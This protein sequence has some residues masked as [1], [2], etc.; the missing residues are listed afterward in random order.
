MKILIINTTKKKY[1]GKVY[2]RMVGEAL[3]NNFKVELINAGIKNGK[4]KYLK[5][6]TILWNLFKVSRK[7]EFDFA[8][9][10][11]DASLFLN[12][13]PTKNIAIVHHIDSSCAP[14]FLKVAYSFF[15]KIVLRNLK[16]FDAIVTVSKYWRDY[17]IERNYKNVYLIYNA[18][19]L[20]EFNF[21]FE[22]IEEFK[23][24]YNL[25]KKPIVYLGN[26]Q[27]AKGV[28]EEYKALKDLDVYLITSGEPMVEI[29]ATNLN[30]SRRNYLKLLKASSIVI[31]MSKFKEGWCRSA[32]ESMLLKTPVIGSGLGGMRELLE[33]GKQIICQDF[34]LLRENVRYLLSHSEARKKMGDNGYSF[35]KDFTLE[36]FE[37]DWLKL[38][39]RLI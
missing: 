39:K 27:K 6:P 16:K 15:E 19:N 35:A 10:D 23:K 18:F 3:S 32:H 7:K 14:L 21:S 24:R 17:F 5:V 13:E 1:G 22:E 38:I 2:E 29:P 33:G 11:F 31:I 28:V 9:K 4:F 8:I 30:L 26:C 37:K 12:K 34:Q 25:T 36:R 20:N